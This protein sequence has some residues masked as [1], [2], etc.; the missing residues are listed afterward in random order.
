MSDEQTD[1]REPTRAFDWTAG[2]RPS[3][4]LVA[5]VAAECDR[6]P[7]DF[8]PLQTAVDADAL[9]ALFYRTSPTRDPIDGTLEFRYLDY[10]VEIR[11]HGRGYL[12]QLDAAERSTAND[13]GIAP[14]TDG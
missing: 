7:T 1:E 10:R 11:S 5:A 2:E 9:D 8:A 12:Y 13:G 4:A 14:E 6:D 3:Q